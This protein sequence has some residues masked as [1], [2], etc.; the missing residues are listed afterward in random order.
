MGIT[1]LSV[2][3]ALSSEASAPFSSQQSVEPQFHTA[4]IRL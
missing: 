1:D 2:Q 3:W 4:L